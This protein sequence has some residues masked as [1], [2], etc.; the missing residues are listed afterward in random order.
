MEYR[1]ILDKKK[2]KK[3]HCPKCNKPKVFTRYICKNTGK[4]AGDNFGVCSRIQACRHTNYPNGID[5]TIK[6]LKRLKPIKRKPLKYLDKAW[7]REQLFRD[8]DSNNFVYHLYNLLGVKNAEDIV[9][10]Y[11]LGTGENGS[12]IY[13]YFDHNYNLVAYKKMHY[14]SNGKRVKNKAYFNSEKNKYPIPLFGIHQI[15]KHP[16]LPIAI[17]ESEKTCC[18]M[19]FYNTNYI[20]CGTGGAGMLNA[21]KIKPIKNRKIILYP[22]VGMFE[23]WHDKMIELKKIFRC[24][25]ITISKE[26]E[27]LY[28]QNELKVGDDIGDYYSKNYYYNHSDRK[29]IGT[30][31]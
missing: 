22:D 12:V 19:S 3:Y 2:N 23:K 14:H 7:Y 25:D 31:M 6:E 20:W 5:W 21:D 13:P 8:N 16:H 29:I 24:L 9:R 26:C 1:Y 30:I 4:E 18:Y 11:K 28:N 27:I 10:N 17:P 15:N